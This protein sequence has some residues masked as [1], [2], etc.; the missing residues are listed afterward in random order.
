MEPVMVTT[1]PYPDVLTA[2]AVD[3]VAALDRAFAARRVTLLER[4]R[5]HRAARTGG[6]G[7]PAATTWIRDDPSWT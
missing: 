7:F 4:R 5:R 6:P 1:S 2:E 3:F